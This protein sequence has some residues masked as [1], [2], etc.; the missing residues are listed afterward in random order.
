MLERAHMQPELAA[1]ESLIRD[2]VARLAIFEDERFA[3]PDRVERDAA[4]RL[5]LVAPPRALSPENEVTGGAP[6]HQRVG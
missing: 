5:P 3:R 4:T 6:L 2:R 1:F